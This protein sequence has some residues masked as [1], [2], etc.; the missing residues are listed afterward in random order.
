[1]KNYKKIFKLNLF[2]QIYTPIILFFYVTIFVITNKSNSHESIVNSQI[3]GAVFLFIPIIILIIINTFFTFLNKELTST[4]KTALMLINFI[5]ILSGIL[6][7]LFNNYFTNDLNNEFD[8]NKRIK[9]NSWI[10]SIMLVIMILFA[11]IY[12]ILDAVVK[13]N[14][15]ASETFAILFVISIFLF[16]FSYLVLIFYVISFHSKPVRERILIC[17][18]FINLFLKY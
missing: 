5:P 16:A 7:L 14:T 18:P 8:F 6:M 17:I 3:F 4:K 2:N 12:S 11:V 13:S 1:M 9:S 10:S 15:E